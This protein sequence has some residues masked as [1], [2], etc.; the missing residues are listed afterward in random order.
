MMAAWAGRS[1]CMVEE[2]G[3]ALRSYIDALEKSVV[4]EKDTKDNYR[5]QARQ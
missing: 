3:V 1:W 4:L 5:G 2:A